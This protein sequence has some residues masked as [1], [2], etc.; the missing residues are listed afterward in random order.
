M[1]VYATITT[2]ASDRY[3]ECCLDSFFRTT[4]L[5][6]EDTVVLI[7]N[8]GTFAQSGKRSCYPLSVKPNERPLGF[9]ENGNYFISLALEREDDLFFFNNDLIF[10]K[11][12]R[13]PLLS[14]QLAIVSPLS[15][16]EVQYAASLVVISNQKVQD[17]FTTKIKMDL[18]DYLGNEAAFNYMSQAHA[19]KCTGNWLVYVLPFFC[20]RLPY[21]VM[22]EVGFFDESFGK[23]GAEDFDYCFRA[24]LAGFSVKYALG[25][26]VLHFGGKSSWSGVETR[27]EQ[28]EREE[29][30][31]SQ[32]AKKWGTK[33]A[34]LV[35]FEDASVLDSVPGM[36]EADQTQ[37]L[38]HVIESLRCI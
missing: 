35:L 31:R 13:E 21:Q 26:Y 11:D 8:D 10:T 9:A 16:R 2:A 5:G 4:K 17:I 27:E 7:D 22:R 29:Y 1:A 15:N 12:W 30:F 23:A 14:E 18:D 3:T 38:R 36:R 28:H 32:F 19:R 6:P 25:A 20:V 37:N 34:R 24:Y 33:L